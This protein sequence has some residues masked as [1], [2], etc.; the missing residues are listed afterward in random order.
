MNIGSGQIS[1]SEN[2]LSGSLTAE[3]VN[4]RSGPPVHLTA[5]WH[6]PPENH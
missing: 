5:R 3:L 4:V 1:F 6:C 2:D